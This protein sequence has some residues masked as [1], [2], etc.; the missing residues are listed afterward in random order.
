MR[1]RTLEL[2]LLIALAA[3]FLTPICGLTA[4][5]IKFRSEPSQQVKVP[6]RLFRTDN[7]WNQLLLDTRTGKLW[8][9]SFGITKDTLRAKVPI[10]TTPLAS[11]TEANEGRFTLYPTDNMWT[12]LLLD[13]LDG[14]VWQC[15]FSTTIGEQMLTPIFDYPNPK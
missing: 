2:I 6:F 8:Q 12:F 7:M 9:V 14:R 4:E 15:Q 13:Q 10:N 3:I 5:T 11:G 1:L